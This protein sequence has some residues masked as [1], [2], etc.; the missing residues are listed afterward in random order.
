MNSHKSSGF[1]MVEL[2]ITVAIVAILMSIAIPSVQASLRESRR[3][4]ARHLLQLNAQRLRRCFTLEGVYNGSCVL[5]TESTDGY[6]SLTSN[7]GIATFDMTA[8]PI[9]SKS[10]SKDIQCLALTYNHLGDEGA[11][12]S[13]GSDCW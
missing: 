1:T 3:Q 5:R 7:V 2:L 6:Y 11:T 13:L 10:Q 12:G 9:A 8:T 4:D